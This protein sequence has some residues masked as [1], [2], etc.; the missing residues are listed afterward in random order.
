MNESYQTTNLQTVQYIFSGWKKINHGTKYIF[1]LEG[2]PLEIK[3]NS[4]NRF[5]VWFFTTGVTGAYLVS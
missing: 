2:T 5:D 4:E 3:T 1:D